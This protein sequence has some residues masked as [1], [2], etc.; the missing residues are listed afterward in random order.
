MRT[1][2]LPF[3]KTLGSFRSSA[4]IEQKNGAHSGA[5]CS[6][7]A[8]LVRSH[9]A[10][11]R[12][13]RNGFAFERKPWGA[14]SPTAKRK[15]FVLCTNTPILSD[16]QLGGLFSFLWRGIEDSHHSAK[17]TRVANSSNL[18][19]L[20]LLTFDCGFAILYLTCTLYIF[21]YLT[22]GESDI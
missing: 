5:V 12:K 1:Q 7:A 3:G 18:N 10:P 16:H 20:L 6:M 11:E 17:H 22:V 14:R 8:E 9:S 4:A 19:Q 2:V 21:L 15:I 13:R